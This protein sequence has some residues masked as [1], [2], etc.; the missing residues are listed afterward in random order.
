MMHDFQCHL[1]LCGIY[2]LIWQ[3]NALMRKSN[4]KMSYQHEKIVV[5]GLGVVSP[6]GSTVPIFWD[7][8]LEGKSGISK[9]TRFDPNPFKC[10]IAGQIH[11]FD[12]RAYYKSKKK[13]KQN[14]LYTHFAVAASHL[15]LQDAGID[16]LAATN[17]IDATKVGIIIG[18]AF[19]GMGSFEEAAIDLHRN[20]PG[21]I[22]PYTIPKILGRNSILKH[23]SMYI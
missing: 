11:D 14:D 9:L 12:P 18:S 10:Q 7:S 13:I 8:L 5:T 21:V 23:M 17:T 15:A 3:S 16:L 20:G 1:I 4:I 19:G 2:L 22:D 6:A